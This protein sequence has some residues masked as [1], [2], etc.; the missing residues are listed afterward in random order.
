MSHFNKTSLFHIGMP[1]LNL[2]E[3][4]TAYRYVG[5]RPPPRHTT[6]RPVGRLAVS[7]VYTTSYKTR[8]EFVYNI[9]I[10]DVQANNFILGKLSHLK[11]I[12]HS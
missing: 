7:L 11:I 10:V 2:Q 1:F 4:S 5:S 6:G 12:I 3:T 9:H 8:P